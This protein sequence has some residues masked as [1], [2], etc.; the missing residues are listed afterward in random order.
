MKREALPDV[1][2][3]TQRLD[4]AFRTVLKVSKQDLLLQSTSRPS[5]SELAPDGPS[6]GQHR[7]TA[8]TARSARSAVSIASLCEFLLEGE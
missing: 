7:L 6:D 4:R 3:E 8:A 1:P 5:V 2:D